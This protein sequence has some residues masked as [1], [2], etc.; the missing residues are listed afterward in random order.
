MT[1]QSAGVP[2][3]E[4]SVAVVAV[5]GRG[6][7][8]HGVLGLA[9]EFDRE[10]VA[11]VAPVAPSPNRS[12]Y[13]QSFLAPI[14]ENEPHLTQ[15]LEIVGDSVEYVADHGLSRDRI[16][17]LGFS[18]GACLAS[19]WVARN[20]RRFGGLVVFSGGL[21]GPPG[22][23]RDYDGSLDGTPVFIGCG[24]RDPH[25]P[26]ER[27]EETASVLEELDATVTERIYEGMSHGI[28][29]DELAAANDLLESV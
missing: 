8:A 11:Y 14:E 4:A 29:E 10:D 7:T 9:D 20:A 26:V 6:A 23:P 16:V 2:L 18:Q 13:P 25:I 3:S 5:H 1:L 19:E 28:N 12:W 21:I 15:A 24:D 17:L 27:V 22:T